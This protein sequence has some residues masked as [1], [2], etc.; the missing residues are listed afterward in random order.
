M[1]SESVTLVLGL[2]E[3]M[4][5]VQPATRGPQDAVFHMS[6]TTISMGWLFGDHRSSCLQGWVTG[7]LTMYLF[8]LSSSFSMCWPTKVIPPVS[9]MRGFAG[10]GGGGGGAAA[11]AS[12]DSGTASSAGSPSGTLGSSS[13]MFP[14]NATRPTT[15]RERERARARALAVT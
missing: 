4:M 14:A 9:R 13:A 11:S 15:L 6:V 8:E 2:V 1:Y 5:Y 7:T 10:L 12:S 3:C